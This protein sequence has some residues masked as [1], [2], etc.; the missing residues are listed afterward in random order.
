MEKIHKGF[1]R[2]AEERM[3]SY[4]LWRCN[5]IGDKPVSSLVDQFEN[6]V[7]ANKELKRLQDQNTEKGITYCMRYPEI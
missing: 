2:N 5:Q 3:L 4:R 7:E 6:L 1:I